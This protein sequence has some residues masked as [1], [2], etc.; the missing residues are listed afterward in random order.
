MSDEIL[1]LIPATILAVGVFVAVYR[2][3]VKK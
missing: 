1:W 3:K 2:V